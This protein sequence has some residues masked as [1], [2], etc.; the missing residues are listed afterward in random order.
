MHLLLCG[1]E[2]SQSMQ[3][4]LVLSSTSLLAQGCAAFVTQYAANAAAIGKVLWNHSP[5]FDVSIEP[6]CN[7]VERCIIL[8]AAMVAFPSAWKHRASGLGLGFIA[9]ELLN[10]V[11]VIS[12]FYLGQWNATVFKVAPS[13]AATIDTRKSKNWDTDSGPTA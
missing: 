11:R 13:S 2:L 6:G 10:M 1:I 8:F 9:V 5:G 4:H 7:G 3:Q 12:F